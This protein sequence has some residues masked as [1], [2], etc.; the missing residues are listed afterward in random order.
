MKTIGSIINDTLQ[1]RGKYSMKRITAF[2][3][4][5]FI[6]ALGTFI[7]ISDKVLQTVIN[8]YGIQ[9]FNSL[10]IF[11]GVLMGLAE[12]RKKFTNKAEQIKEEE[13]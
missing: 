11:Q 5:T 8:P 2:V 4:M 6:L 7:V 3:N 9:V 1:S 13:E 12:A 10:L